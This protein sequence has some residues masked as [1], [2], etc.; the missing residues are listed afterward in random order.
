[1]LDTG[2]SGALDGRTREAKR[3]REVRDGLVADLGRQ[4]SHGDLALIQTAAVS[5]V[6]AET[7]QARA[8]GGGGAS[9]AELYELARLGNLTCRAVTRL[10]LRAGKKLRRDPGML[11]AYLSGKSEGAK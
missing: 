3:Y 6:A 8:V 4:P 11:D 1:M 7:I 5:I 9:I 10:S 2:R